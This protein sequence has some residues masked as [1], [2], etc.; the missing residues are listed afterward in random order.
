MLI[1]AICGETTDMNPTSTRSSADDT[2]MSS[3]AA[4]ASSHARSIAL[5]VEEVIAALGLANGNDSFR[6]VYAIDLRPSAMCAFA[7]PALLSH[8][9]PSHP[10]VLS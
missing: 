9:F 2:A 5:E 7:I 6:R 1:I 4:Q 10:S 8:T 3:P